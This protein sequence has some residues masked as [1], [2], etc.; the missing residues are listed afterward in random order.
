MGVGLVLAHEPATLEPVEEAHLSARATEKRR[1][2]FALGRTAARR[3]MR[4][5][6]ATP[7]AVGRTEDRA[8][9]WPDGL[10]G[11]ISH[12]AGVGLAVVAWQKRARGLGVDLEEREASV[13][14][15]MAGYI[16]LPEEMAWTDAADLAT[17]QL[18]RVQVFAAKEAI[19]KALYPLEREYLGFHDAVLEW[20]GDRFR[21]T[22]RKRAAKGFEVGARLEVHAWTLP[23]AVLT[24]VWI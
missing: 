8:P 1:R 15:R 4:D 18:R 12:S 17:V 10:V 2:D 23:E 11:A 7:A 6:G 20:L 24:F 3:A 22:L 14:D 16:C 19:F 21:A 5:L 13:T 9:V